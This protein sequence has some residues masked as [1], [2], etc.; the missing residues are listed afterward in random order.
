VVAVGHREYLD[1]PL[2]GYAGRLAPG[3]CF[4]DVKAAFDRTALAAR[5]WR[6]W[7]L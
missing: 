7:R 4:V 5:G 1:R 2:D 6:V 3:G